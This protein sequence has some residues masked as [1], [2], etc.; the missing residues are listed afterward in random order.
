MHVVNDDNEDNRIFHEQNLL[1]LVPPHTDYIY[2][3][4]YN[5]SNHTY[6]KSIK[7]PLLNITFR[8]GDS[9]LN[10]FSKNG[11]STASC[12]DSS[13]ATSML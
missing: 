1:P 9:V 12:T 13:V 5:C 7:P 8:K 4:S 6:R 2:K 3:T 10:F 11:F